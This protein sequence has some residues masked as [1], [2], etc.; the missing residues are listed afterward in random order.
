L[1]IAPP[2]VDALVEGGNA[3]HIKRD[4]GEIALGPA[5]QGGDGL[6]RDLDIRARTKFA[7]TPDRAETAAVAYRS[8]ALQEAARQ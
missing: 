3:G 1:E 2:C 8:R 7:R 6:D 5:Q 4:L